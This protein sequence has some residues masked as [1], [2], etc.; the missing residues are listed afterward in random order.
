MVWARLLMPDGM[1]MI[2]HGIDISC[3][4]NKIGAMNWAPTQHAINCRMGMIGC[5]VGKASASRQTEK[6]PRGQSKPT[7]LL[8]KTP[9]PSSRHNH[10]HHTHNYHHNTLQAKEIDVEA[11]NVEDLAGELPPLLHQ[12][13]NYANV[14]PL[15]LIQRF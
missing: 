5:E 15:I 13:Q 10:Y 6:R 2:N 9:V 4:A 7:L 8:L 12:K 11:T 14:S 3:N 1:G